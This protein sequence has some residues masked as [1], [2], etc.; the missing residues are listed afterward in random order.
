MLMVCILNMLLLGIF[1]CVNNYMGM[2][3]VGLS[4]AF[5]LHTQTCE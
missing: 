5:L 3:I 2:N 1:G 4:T